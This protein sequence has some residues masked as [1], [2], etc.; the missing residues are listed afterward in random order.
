[1]LNVCVQHSTNPVSCFSTPALSN[2]SR[3]QYNDITEYIDLWEK[4]L[5]AEAAVQSVSDCA[6]VQL[7]QNVPLKWPTLQQP[8]TSLDNIH[9][10]P[11]EQS[12]S[13]EKDVG[14]TWTIT[15]KF[16]DRCGEYF[17]IQVGNLVCTRYN[18]PLTEEKKVKGRSVQTASA[19]YHFVID[20]IDD[21]DKK[22]DSSKKSRGRKS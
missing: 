14:V 17:E 19:V 6:V 2:A 9:Y 16:I 5:L 7:I 20:K 21:P 4:V 12:T 22:D 18:I 11:I 15:D 1:M 13:T 10:S 8:S 3:T